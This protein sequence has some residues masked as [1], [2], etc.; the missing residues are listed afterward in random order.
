MYHKHQ[1][2]PMGNPY[3]IALYNVGI[4]GVFKNP[5]QNPYVENTSFF[6]NMGKKPYVK[7][8]FLP[9]DSEG[10]RIAF[11]GFM[12]YLCLG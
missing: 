6:S 9:Y 10:W 12:V 2:T 7:G 8:G 3:R 11:Q 4:S 5:L 1:R